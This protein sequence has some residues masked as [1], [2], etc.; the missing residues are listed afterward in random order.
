MEI[1]CT[2]G[3]VQNP[4]CCPIS[5]QVPRLAPNRAVKK[6]G[7]PLPKARNVIPA[8]SGDSLQYLD[9]CCRVEER[10]LSAMEYVK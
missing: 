6:S 8:M 1:R 5:W 3:I 4:H 2:S 9:R 10:C 7:A